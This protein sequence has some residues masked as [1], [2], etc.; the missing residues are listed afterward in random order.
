VYQKLK[1]LNSNGF[2]LIEIIASITLLGTIVAI[3]L[4]VFPQII[5]WTQNSD[6]ELVASN[7]L[8]QV[9]Y[10]IKDIDIN[11]SLPLPSCEGNK[12]QL[13]NSTYRNANEL[14]EKIY[15]IELFACKEEGVNLYRTNIQIKKDGNILS[16]SYTYITGDEE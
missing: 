8:S 13:D 3:L 14:N 10:D 9:A 12:K 7:L 4:P 1:K 16:E 2:T 15:N 5:S 6:D 11:Q